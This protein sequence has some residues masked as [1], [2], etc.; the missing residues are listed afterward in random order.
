MDLKGQRKCER[1]FL[2]IMW[3]ATALSCVAGFAADDVMAIFKVFGGS[4]AVCALLC[5]PD[6]P[7]Y[8]RNAIKFAADPRDD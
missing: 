2:Y 1:L 8:N 4:L 3:P 7:M 6:W 5:L